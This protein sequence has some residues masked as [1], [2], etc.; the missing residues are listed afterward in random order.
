MVTQLLLPVVMTMFYFS[1]PVYMYFSSARHS[2]LQWSDDSVQSAINQAISQSTG[3]FFSTYPSFIFVVFSWFKC[4]KF[5]DGKWYLDMDPNMECN[6]G[7]HRSLIP[8]AALA[9][10]I[11]CAVPLVTVFLLLRNFRANT[12]HLEET[13]E[14]MGDIYQHYKTD[15]LMWESLFLFKVLILVSIQVYLVDSPLTQVLL[16]MVFHLLTLGLHCYAQPYISVN[17][18]RLESV[19]LSIVCMFTIGGTYFYS[20][21]VGGD[22]KEQW[23]IALLFL[24]LLG[25]VMTPLAVAFDVL[26]TRSADRAV[27]LLNHRMNC[28][29]AGRSQTIDTEETVTSSLSA[30]S[31]RM[32]HLLRASMSS[33]GPQL[34]EL[35]T[36][37]SFAKM[38]SMSSW[39]SVRS[40]VMPEVHLQEIQN[41]IVGST[42][43]KWAKQFESTCSMEDVDQLLFVDEL[44]APSVSDRSE[45]S[46]FSRSRTSEFWRR[47]AYSFP[48]I[49]L[50]LRHAD[51]AQV[52]TMCDTL[53]ELQEYDADVIDRTTPE[54][55]NYAD[56][57]RPEDLSSIVCWLAHAEGAHRAAFFKILNQVV[58]ANGLYEP[59]SSKHVKSDDRTS[60]IQQI[61]WSETKGALKWWTNIVIGG[62]YNPLREPKP[63]VPLVDPNTSG[64]KYVTRS[65]SLIRAL[66]RNVGAGTLRSAW[67]EVSQAEQSE[68][69]IG[70]DATESCSSEQSSHAGRHSLEIYDAERHHGD[71]NNKGRHPGEEPV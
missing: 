44:I 21:D 70:Q 34:T 32:I 48:N 22:D 71:C 13:L 14:R 53:R 64:P 51:E 39:T 56:F 12:L 65:T 36:V 57:I 29:I 20:N 15:F 26:N 47:I 7:T 37:G 35:P 6:T 63:F 69:A 28:L 24:F 55:A 45:T 40:R 27:A 9:V 18:N 68:G 62:A 5:V 8:I 38:R 42:F 41:T 46:V 4:D 60:T 52:K 31:T 17:V 19:L 2:G 43:Y 50:F 10:P 30:V 3:L 1:K 33:K 54:V 49:M 66:S 67:G 11:G 25:A 61:T 59:T 16:S 23:S 58:R